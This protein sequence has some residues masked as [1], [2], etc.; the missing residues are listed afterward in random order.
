MPASPIKQ[1]EVALIAA[2][3]LRLIDGV[4]QE[5]ADRTGKRGLDRLDDLLAQPEVAESNGEAD[6]RD[7]ALHEHERRHERERARMAEAVRGAQPHERVLDEVHAAGLEKRLP[8]VV[9]RQLPGLRDLGGGAHAAS[10]SA[11]TQTVI[12]AGSISMSSVL[13][14]LRSPPSSS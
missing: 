6:E 11:G 13:T 10:A 7:E 5:V 12:A 4:G 14:G 3:L 2:D 1:R 9:P 8:G